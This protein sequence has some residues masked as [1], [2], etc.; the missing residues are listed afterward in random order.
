MISTS[1]YVLFKVHSEYSVLSILLIIKIVPWRKSRAQCH[2]PLFLWFTTCVD[3]LS[4][5][6]IGSK[7]VV[8]SQKHSCC[9]DGFERLLKKGEIMSS[10]TDLNPD[11]P[12][13][14]RHL[15]DT[16]M[17]RTDVEGAELVSLLVTIQSIVK[18]ISSA[19]RR[20]GISK[21]FG[22]Q[23][24]T[25]VQGEEQQKLDILANQVSTQNHL[26]SQKHSIKTKPLYKPSCRFSS[27]SFGILTPV[28]S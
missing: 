6:T 7:P 15:L 24:S 12:T 25:N 19:V 23:G 21:L 16:L 28:V 17:K 8:Q 14:T 9:F 5:R 1:K 3:Q 26:T 27:I 4:Y 13:L 10:N 22:A 18:N 20:A 2:N 11:T